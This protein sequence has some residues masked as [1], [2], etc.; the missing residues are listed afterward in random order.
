ML[1][2]HRCT[3]LGSRTEPQAR[4]GS[5]RTHHRHS[6]NLAVHAH[7]RVHA[8]SVQGSV[9]AR[10]RHQDAQVPTAPFNLTQPRPGAFKPCLQKENPRDVVGKKK[11]R[12]SPLEPCASLQACVWQEKPALA[13]QCPPLEL[14]GPQ[15]MALCRGTAAGGYRGEPCAPSWRSQGA[16]GRVCSLPREQPRQPASAPRYGWVVL[17]TLPVN[18]AIVGA[19][20]LSHQPL[21]LPVGFW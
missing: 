1:R 16:P 14:E 18:L 4:Q 7:T 11:L 5:D 21:P 3:H 9:C 10:H 2:P 17:T 12:T 15:A 20:S 8:V 6:C 19:A 13:Q